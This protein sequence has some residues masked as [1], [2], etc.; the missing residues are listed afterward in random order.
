MIDYSVLLPVPLIRAQVGHAAPNPVQASPQ[1]SVGQVVWQPYAESAFHS[2]PRRKLNQI[3]SRA[4]LLTAIRPAGGGQAISIGETALECA[5]HLTPTTRIVLRSLC[6][7]II[8]NA[9][10]KPF[11]PTTSPIMGPLESHASV[12]VHFWP[13][14]WGGLLGASGGGR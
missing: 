4:Q 1:G 10:L 3:T 5:H 7:V 8:K 14:L 12:A 6:I 9:E 11:R 2:R 13:P